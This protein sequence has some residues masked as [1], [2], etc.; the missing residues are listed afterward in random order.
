MISELNFVGERLLLVFIIVLDRLRIVMLVLVG[1]IGGGDV[2]CVC[3]SSVL[4]S[5]MVSW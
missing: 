1:A 5:G 4:V 2:V 3:I